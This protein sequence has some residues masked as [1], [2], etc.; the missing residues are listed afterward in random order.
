MDETTITLLCSDWRAIKMLPASSRQHR[1][2]HLDILPGDFPS[3]PKLNQNINSMAP[4]PLNMGK[5]RSPASSIQSISSSSTTSSTSSASTPSRYRDRQHS[6]T[7]RQS[8]WCGRCHTL[9]RPLD[10][11]QWASC[12]ESHRCQPE[13]GEKRR[14]RREWRVCEI[15]DREKG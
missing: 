11:D 13:E 1:Q 6:I 8:Y 9:V 15:K 7:R 3:P 5:Q 12:G 14:R 10:T 2:Q 4:S